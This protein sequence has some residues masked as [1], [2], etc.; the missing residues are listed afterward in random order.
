MIQIIHATGGNNRRV[1]RFTD[2]ANPPNP[3]TIGTQIGGKPSNILPG[4]QTIA[5]QAVRKDNNTGACVG[6][7]PDNTD[8]SVEMASQCNNPGTCI[9]ANKVG[10]TN[11]ST[12]ALTTLI[13]NNPSAAVTS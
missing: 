1:H 11:S 9:A 6:V 10:V 5:L 3:I 12:P 13:N 4:T 7:F 8:V 2:G